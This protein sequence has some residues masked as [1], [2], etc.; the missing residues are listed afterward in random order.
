[1]STRPTPADELDELAQQLDAELEP[2]LQWIANELQGTAEQCQ[3][4]V[5]DLPPLP[6]E[7]AP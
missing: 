7:E 1:M 6:W 3:Q 2:G 5:K 4:F